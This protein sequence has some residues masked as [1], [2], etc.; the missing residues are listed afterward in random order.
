MIVTLDLKSSSRVTNA[1]NDIQS[2]IPKHLNFKPKN[3]KLHAEIS[4]R[5]KH[6]ENKQVLQERNWQ[7]LK[8]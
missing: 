6:M 3:E 1:F 8:M 7:H 5:A 4:A 2:I